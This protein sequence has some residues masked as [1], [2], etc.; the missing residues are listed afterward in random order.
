[1]HRNRRFLSPLRTVA[2]ATLIATAGAAMLP[3]SL[4]P[5]ASAAQAARL[6]VGDPAPTLTIAEFLKGDPVTEFESGKVYVV[7]FWATWCAP[8]IKAFPHLSDLQRQYGDQVEVIGVNIWERSQG[9]ARRS[10]VSDFV[11]SQGSNMSYT[12]ALEQGQSMGENWMRAAGQGGIPAA[13][14]VDQDGRIAWIGHPMSMDQPL[15]QIV[16]G[17]W[18]VDAAVKQQ[19]L[20]KQAEGILMQAQQAMQSGD[21]DTLMVKLDEV[22]ALDAP[23]FFNISMAKLNILAKEMNDY[24]AAWAWGREMLTNQY[25]DE[26]QALNTVAYFILTDGGLQNRDVELALDMAKRA[27]EVAEGVNPDV[28]DTLAMAYNAAGQTDKAIEAATQAVLHA[29]DEREKAT[30]QSNLDAYKAKAAG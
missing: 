12:V 14:I 16:A 18:D 29:T 8:C 28:L 23:T 9:E 20:V 1:M 13:F 2:A 25:K 22:I 24:D 21:M 19:N 11:K 7:E 5:T 3:A 17:E 26:W 6:G 10:K 27:N 15:A 30:F 4:A